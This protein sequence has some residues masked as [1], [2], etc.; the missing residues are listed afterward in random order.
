MRH[1]LKS[2]KTIAFTAV[3]AAVM[4]FGSIAYA[5]SSSTPFAKIYWGNN[6]YYLFNNTWGSNSAS[7]GWWQSIYYNNNYDMGWT[8]NWGTANPGSVKA[9]PSIVSG[10]HW[11]N[12]YTTGSGF[13]TRIWDN[14][15]INASVNYSIS[16]NGTYNAAYDIWVHN[17]NNA[18][19]NSTP[20]DE[21]MIWLN[22][23]NAGPLGSYVETVSIAGSSWRLYK[24]WL[25]AGNGTG[26]N[27]FSF[28]R[29][30]NTSS[31]SMNLRDFIHYVV[32]TKNWMSNSKFISSVEFGSE[33]FTGSG[34]FH[35]N[36]YSVNVQ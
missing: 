8:W 30:S 34:N 7:S 17:T 19:D 21:I 33:I 15:N 28:V 9:Y 16:A 18:V 4:L 14:K 20:T 24:G 2:K 12:G 11:T 5:A 22:N 6:K 1:M 31:S 13:P 23:T 25:N 3:L 10:W 27:V 29:T 36:S 26:W 32:Y 35:I